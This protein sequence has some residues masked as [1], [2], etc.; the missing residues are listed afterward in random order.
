MVRKQGYSRYK[1]NTVVQV[2]LNIRV[3]IKKGSQGEKPK[4]IR[5]RNYYSEET[6]D[7]SARDQ[8]ALLF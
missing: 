5:W 6:Q 1:A 2:R 4:R 8:A 7:H 3:E